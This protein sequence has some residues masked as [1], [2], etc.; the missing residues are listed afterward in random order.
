MTVGSL[1]KWGSKIGAKAFKGLF[2]AGKT[3]SASRALVPY[4]GKAAA[5][6][7]TGATVG[8]KALKYGKYAVG[9]LL[10]A[11]AVG[12]LAGNAVRGAVAAGS[13]MNSENYGIQG[14]EI[15]QIFNNGG[16]PVMD[17][18]GYLPATGDFGMNPAMMGN[19]GIDFSMMGF[20]NMDMLNNFGINTNQSGAAGMVKQGGLMGMVMQLLGFILNIFSGLFR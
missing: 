4:A 15:G 3:V 8:S 16:Y 7:A 13:I 14:A 12:S 10:V 9:G 20:D 6:A 2:G 11:D 5:G 19:F 18:N 17:G 1:I